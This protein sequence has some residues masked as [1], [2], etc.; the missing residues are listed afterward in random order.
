[1]V[2]EL[3][4]KKAARIIQQG[5]LVAFPTETVY[6]LGAD[7][8]N[9]Q[10]VARIFEVKER[11]S[12]DPLIV[13][14]ASM[15]TLPL[16]TE[17]IDKRV[18]ELADKFWPGPLT[19]V[20]PK[21]KHVPDIVTS[22]LPTVGIRMP[23]H[24]VALEL[25]RYA[26]CPIAAPSANKFGKISPT[27]ACHVRKQLTEVTC[28]LDG[29]NT[30][31]GIESTVITLN[32]DGFVILRQG[33][34]TKNDLEAILPQSE[35]EL[36]KEIKLA[37]PG[38]LKSHYSPDKP[39]FISGNCDFPFDKS[40]AGFLSFSL[41]DVKGYKIVEYLSDNSD[42]KQAAVNLFGAMHRLEDAEIDFIVAEPLPE[43]GIG[44]AIMDRLNKAAYKSGRLMTMIGSEK[45]DCTKKHG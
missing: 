12:F 23:D 29:G 33:Y 22:G 44:I 40:K 8:F 11:P 32:P 42:L 37:S 9:P 38:L 3:E 10:A 18:Y 5:G 24:P 41:K 13:H 35:Q 25:I 4:I 28:V 2:N 39:F 1:M 20:L 15:D 36:S 17:N 34:I 30:S 43:H 7:A 45:S 31:I 14:V 19:I 16:L 26:G 27:S 21:S 6:G